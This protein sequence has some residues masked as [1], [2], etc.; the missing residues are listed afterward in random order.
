[1]EQHARTVDFGQIAEIA[2]AM[3]NKAAEGKTAEEFQE[4]FELGKEA[5]EAGKEVVNK[6]KAAA[7]VAAAMVFRIFFD[8]EDAAA[9][10]LEEETAFDQVVSAAVEQVD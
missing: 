5:F 6:A 9:R 2:E 10:S 4:I 7:K 8:E 1:M 3:V